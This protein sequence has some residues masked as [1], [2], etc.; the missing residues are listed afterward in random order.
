[1]ARV[2][3]SPITAGMSQSEISDL[4][5]F[6][7][8]KLLE[9]EGIS[10]PKELP[11]KVHFGEEGNETYV[12]PELYDGIIEFLKNS[13]VET[14]YMET[15]VLYRGQRTTREKH[16]D[17][18]E[19]HGFTQIPIRIADGEHGEASSLVSINGNH[20]KE[21]KIATGFAEAEMVLVTSHFKGHILAKFGGALKQ[22][23]MGFAAR[24]GKLDMHAKSK[25]LIDP[26][27]CKKC[28]KCMEKCPVDAI[29]IGNL[30]SKI[31][32]KICIG[33]AT[34]IAV[35]P[36]GA[37]KINW[38]STTGKSFREKLMEYALAAQKGKD[39]I[40]L[41]YAIN[42]TA[43]CDCM[44][45]VMKPK[46]PDLGI[47][48]SIDPVAVEKATLDLLDESIGKKSFGGRE[49]LEYASK[50]GLG[51]PEYELVRL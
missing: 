15:N 23:G 39:N 7:F 19:K 37:V 30:S 13:K 20:F 5:A 16:V 32:R 22:L 41:N 45:K 33:C 11:I 51:S 38:A 1:M 18:A 12:K 21:C 47:I 4:A 49:Q 28:M 26:I 48:A 36:Y 40:Y 9:D 14:F 31:N 44:G 6:A 50:I 25:P 42:I 17:L 27:K 34:C 46:Y 43:Q 3:F 24:G 8:K 29:T 10:L 35:C 2:Y